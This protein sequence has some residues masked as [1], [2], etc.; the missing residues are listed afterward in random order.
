M[1]KTTFLLVVLFCTLLADAQSPQ[2]IPYQAVARDSF[3]TP[4]PNQAMK[5]RMSI[6]TGSSG[7]TVVYQE[8]DTFT[9][10]KL[11]MFTVNVGSGTVVIGTFSTID[12]AGASK[13][14]QVE[15]DPAGGTSYVDMGA[16]QLLSVPFALHA[17][18]SSVTNVPVKRVPYGG[19]SG[20]SSD[21]NFTRDA[22]NGNTK[23]KA[24][25][26]SDFYSLS[27][28]DSN[29]LDIGGTMMSIPSSVLSYGDTAGDFAMHIGVG[30]VPGYG[31]N[32][33][34][35]LNLSN[36]EGDYAAI[37]FLENNEGD[38][39]IIAGV[40]ETGEG[41]FADAG[42]IMQLETGLASLMWHNDENHMHGIVADSLTLKIYSSSTDYNWIWP[43]T[44]GSSGKA[45]ATDGSG[46]LYWKRVPLFSTA[47]GQG[48]LYYGSAADTVAVLAKDTN[49]TRYLSNTGSSNAPAWSQVNLSNGVTGNL[50]VSNLNSGTS[51]SA[52]TFWR[53]DGTWAAPSGYALTVAAL[54]FN[55]ADN[56]TYYMGQLP[57]LAPTTT[58]A[59]RRLLV[60][61]TGTL[62]AAYLLAYVNGTLGSATNTSFYVR[63]NNT[64]DYTVS[65]TVTLNATV[66]SITNSSMSAS[67]TA[68][69]YLEIKVVCP[70]WA[71]NPT[72]V[73]LSGSLY[74]E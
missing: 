30:K 67:V 37:D 16:S 64:T 33:F 32:Q 62:K 54:T 4:L 48:G 18:S 6:R 39:M 35:F 1:K 28:G 57:A 59:T 55:P 51:A 22:A 50:P 2:S 52:T 73:V 74:I 46:N 61:K 15:V 21:N 13:Y 24:V 68:G 5:A 42:S 34:G 12:W 29:T 44:D 38:P 71:T 7:G 41:A 19:S 17:A 60:P 45:L 53:G 56:A 65:T 8:T 23:I 20:L 36:S 9:T 27:L 63:L 43:N 40:N 11:G 58:T 31:I 72:N 49:T 3:G 66:V 14:L 69:D 47:I 70:T 26:G 10:S 25:K